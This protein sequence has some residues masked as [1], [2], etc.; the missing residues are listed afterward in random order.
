[1]FARR[2]WSV[3]A[4]AFA[5]YSKETS[6]LL[7]L[8]YILLAEDR[9]TWT[10]WLTVGTMA[11]LFV[12]SR[13]WL[14]IHYASPPG[15][16]FWYPLRNLKWL[17]TTLLFDFWGLPF[18]LLALAR[19]VMIWPAFPRGLRCLLVLGLIQIGMAFFKGWIEEKR[20]YLELLVPAGLIVIQ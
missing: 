19:C 1:I 10:F 9:R 11:A 15:A 8:A 3:L 20:Q 4:F 14:G 5:A 17:G 13:F 12:S 6:V 7:I 18:L 2:P 16:D